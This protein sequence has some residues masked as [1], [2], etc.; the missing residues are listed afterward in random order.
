MTE[1]KSK[2]EF[3]V[4]NSVKDLK[5]IQKENQEVSL[6]LEK[7]E[8]KLQEAVRKRELALDQRNKLDCEARDQ[9]KFAEKCR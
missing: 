3:Q 1:E 2:L 9:L 8:K 7:E 6:A 5:G 4:E